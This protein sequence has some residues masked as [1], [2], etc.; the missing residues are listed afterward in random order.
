MNTRVSVK[1]E[2]IRWA[3]ERARLDLETLTKTFAKL[4]EWEA[5]TCQPTLKELG[6][7]AKKVHVPV[8]YLFF[9]K[10]P[11][12]SLSIPDFR[13][14]EGKDIENPSPELID[15]FYSCQE[16]QEWYRD[17][18][19]MSGQP[20]LGFIGSASLKT[21]H[22]TVAAEMR[23]VLN[24]SPDTLRKFR[25]DRTND[26]LSELIELT[27]NAGILVMINGVVMN[28][29]HRRLDPKEFRGFALSDEYAPLIFI[30]GKDTEAAKMFTL[31]H[32]LAHLWLGNSAL[33]NLE[34]TKPP[35]SPSEPRSYKE[36]EVWCN[37]VA[38]E[39]LVPLSALKEHLSRSKNTPLDNLNELKQ[40][41][42]VSDLVILRRLLDGNWIDRKKFDATYEEKKQ[43][44]AQKEKAQKEK[45]Q[46]VK[47]QKK[48]PSIRRKRRIRLKH[49]GR[50]FAQALVT[51]TLEGHTLYRDA[52]RML[53]ISKTEQFKTLGREVKVI[54]E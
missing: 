42:K 43:K 39:F 16:R 37:A 26:A 13:I 10:P 21:P 14:L 50:R 27:E 53:G 32:E 20:P 24:Y 35:P 7:F 52:F 33:S 18:A 44:Y 45:A 31:A 54:R 6:Q 34:T 1:P 41:F 28:N 48:S 49:V 25:K 40:A 17:Y 22:K 12:E 8:G 23:K 2:L 15:T 29:V 19:Q 46:T 38:A 11:R 36:E 3:R 51:D 9:S 47:A 4:P 30:N 5:G